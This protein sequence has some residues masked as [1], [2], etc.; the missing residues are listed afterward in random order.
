[1]PGK[2]VRLAVADQAPGDDPGVLTLIAKSGAVDCVRLTSEH[3]LAVDAVLVV[4]LQDFLK[5]VK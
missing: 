3:V 4:V 1:M 5:Y 2:A